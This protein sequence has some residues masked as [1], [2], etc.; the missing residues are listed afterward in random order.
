MCQSSEEL[1]K[2]NVQKQ[3]LQERQANQNNHQID[4]QTGP[5]MSYI[6][7]RRT[8]DDQQ[9]ENG[10]GQRIEHRD[11]HA[12]KDSMAVSKQRSNERQATKQTNFHALKK[13]STSNNVVKLEKKLSYSSKMKSEI[14]DANFKN[15]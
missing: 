6:S 5:F 1:L 14:F 15:Y 3:A 2:P 7:S 12:K 11:K 8:F 13:S 9:E 4:Q 10:Q